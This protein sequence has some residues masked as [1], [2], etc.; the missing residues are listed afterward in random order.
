MVPR[1]LQINVVSADSDRRFVAEVQKAIDEG[2]DVIWDS[3]R[4][5]ATNDSRQKIV[6]AILLRKEGDIV[7]KESL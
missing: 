6:F 7:E 4:M 5:V 1:K 2:W 3:F